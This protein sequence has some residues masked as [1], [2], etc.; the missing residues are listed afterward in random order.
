VDFG[1][2]GDA[3]RQDLLARL[4]QYQWAHSIDLGHGVVTPGK[5][6]PPNPALLAA[7]NRIDFKGKKVLD[8]GC[9][10]GLWSF[11]AEKRGASAVYATDDVSQRSFAEQPTFA[12]VH[13]ALQSQVK[14]LPNLSIYDV[15]TLG[16]DDFDVVVFS[17]VY[18]HL[19]HPLLA[20]AILRQVTATGG[21][22]IVEGPVIE[23]VK[24]SFATF[25]Y[26]ETFADDVS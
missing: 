19:R 15:R 22:I 18:Y 1:K 2:R 26:H 3:S 9:W 17:G 11:E 7:Y 4:G 23:N 16:V 21:H 6:G 14:Y 25:Y 20:L 12:L 8:I 10:D 24:D 5:W 13:E